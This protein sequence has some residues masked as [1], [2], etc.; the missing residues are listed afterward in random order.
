MAGA[1]QSGTVKPISSPPESQTGKIGWDF[2]REVEML[3]IH[4]AA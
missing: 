1:Q 2:S 4:S 3:D